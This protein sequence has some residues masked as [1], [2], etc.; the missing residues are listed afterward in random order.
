MLLLAA[1][2]TIEGSPIPIVRADAALA[3]AATKMEERV[4]VLCAVESAVEPTKRLFA[5]H[6]SG[7]A[8]SVE[9]VHVEQV[10]ALFTNN[11]LD[12]CFAAIAAAADDAYEAGATVVAYAHPWMAPAVHLTRK[13]TQ[14][15]D[16]AHAALHTAIQQIGGPSF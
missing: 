9:V 13:G 11:R 14:P 4:V 7:A 3:A 10:W 5:Q 6:A 12:E 8:T 16:S 15:L 1:A 2:D